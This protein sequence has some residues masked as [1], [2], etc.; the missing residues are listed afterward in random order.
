VSNRGFWGCFWALQ[1]R[2]APGSIL[3]RFAPC[4]AGFD[5][6]SNVS[7]V[8]LSEDNRKTQLTAAADV[9]NRIPRPQCAQLG[10]TIPIQAYSPKDAGQMP[11]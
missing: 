5:A 7:L 6:K 11:F 4:A 9:P 3:R 10:M 1:S 8:R 2:P